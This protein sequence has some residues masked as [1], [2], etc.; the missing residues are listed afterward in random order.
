MRDTVPMTKEALAELPDHRA[1]RP[2]VGRWR[3][4]L[5]QETIVTS[6]VGLIIAAAVLLPLVT[7]T[8]NSFLVLDDLGFDTEWGLDNYPEMFRDRLIRKAFFNT[9]II[10][11]GTTILA[12]FLGVSLAWLNA[13]TNCP[14]REQLEP[15]N[16]I[17]FFLSPFIGAIAWHNL[18]APR[19]G[20][21]GGGLG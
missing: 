18:A 9:L 13:R 19:V 3:R 10:S 5:N 12:T 14:W 11:S 20:M 17:P 21:L 6:L 8:V 16:L 2:V 1:T 15:F 7:L 4:L